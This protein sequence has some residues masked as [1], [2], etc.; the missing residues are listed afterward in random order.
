MDIAT[1]IGLLVSAALIVGSVIIGGSPQMFV[2]LPSVLVVVGGTI[3]VTLVKNPLPVVLKTFAVSGKAFLHKLPAPPGLIEEIIELAKAARKNGI[4]ALEGKEVSY[5]FLEKG[6]GMGVDGMDIERIQA[7]LENDMRSTIARHKTGRQI[8]EGMGEAAPAFGMIGTLIGLV[9]MLASLD[10]P[11]SIGPAMAVALLTTLYGALLANV[12]FLPL[13]EKLRMRSDEEKHVMLM[14]VD[15]IAG[16][17]AGDNP[18][19]IDQR[20]KAFVAPKMREQQQKA[21]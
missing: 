13:A 5:D 14:C 2:N 3:G 7:V 21:A 20:L 16:I 15:G 8:L 1:I 4:L 11:S 12:V 19:M 9:Q 6:V 18:N 17:V 10:D